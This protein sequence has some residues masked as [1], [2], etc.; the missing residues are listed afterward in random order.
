[1]MINKSF[2]A[3]AGLACAAAISPGV[4]AQDASGIGVKHQLADPLSNLNRLVGVELRSWWDRQWGASAFIYHGR[5]KEEGS[6][7]SESGTYMRVGLQGM[8]ALANTTNTTSYFGIQG[9]YQDFDEFD[10]WSAM[11][12]LGVEFRPVSMQHI[13]F[14]VETGYNYSSFDDGDEFV[15]Q[16]F[17]NQV[18]MTYYF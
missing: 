1:M 15:V 7:G 3:A 5:W 14:H 13:G 12:L 18:G 2:F 10:G 17:S 16:G 6:W 9:S 11:P 8:K 4:S